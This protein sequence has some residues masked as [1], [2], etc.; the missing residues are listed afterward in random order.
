MSL[1][2]DLLAKG[3][4]P[5]QLPPGFTSVTFASNRVGYE[6]AWAAVEKK[7]QTSG[8]RFS[9]ARSSYYRRTTAILNPI[10]FYLLAKEIAT[11]WPLIQ[12]HYERS[13]L[14]RSTPG[15]DGSPPRHMSDEV[16]RAA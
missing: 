11:H 5:V 15:E 14:S 12:K 8:E 6:A 7:P 9:V 1:L 10:G 2:D 16:Q 13:E 4:F 3:Y